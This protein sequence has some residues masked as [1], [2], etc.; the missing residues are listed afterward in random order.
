MLSLI[1]LA[2]CE[3]FQ[4]PIPETG[5]GLDTGAT[6][7]V[8][9]REDYIT[10]GQS[11]Y[12]VGETGHLTATLLKNGSE[13][14]W[15]DWEWSAERNS[16]ISSRNANHITVSSD[17]A[18]S[19][20]V[21]AT[22]NNLPGST[23]TN[24]VKA[25]A[26]HDVQFIKQP[27]CLGY[28][29]WSPAYE[30]EMSRSNGLINSGPSSGS[31]I[32]TAKIF[33]SEVPDDIVSSYMKFG[34]Y[35]SNGRQITTIEFNNPHLEAK[36]SGSYSHYSD[37]TRVHIITKNSGQVIL[38]TNNYTYYYLQLIDSSCEAVGG[39]WYDLNYDSEIRIDDYGTHYN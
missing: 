20:A 21:T 36:G 30:G 4:N 32:F 11:N 10:R 23:S 1:F 17:V 8:V 22:A 6:Y 29:F 26:A 13:M 28:V 12:Q 2:S 5:D 38:T 7:S 24:K 37:G 27:H 31:V 3:K 16:I 33:M 25:F 19:S 18:C 39:D 14:E 9:I 15:N 34:V 35:D